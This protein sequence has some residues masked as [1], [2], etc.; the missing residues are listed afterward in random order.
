MVHQILI[1]LQT[2]ISKIM[3]LLILLLLERGGHTSIFV[4][5]VGLN[6]RPPQSGAV[7]V[8]N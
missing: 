6:L 4:P 1:T 7:A 5:F 8:R 3:Y 2:H